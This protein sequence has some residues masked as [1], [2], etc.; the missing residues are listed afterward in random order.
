MDVRKD[1]LFELVHIFVE[2]HGGE[3]VKIRLHPDVDPEDVKKHIDRM[4]D[5]TISPYYWS[6]CGRSGVVNYFQ[7]V[8]FPSK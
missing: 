6:A 2:K 3:I 4:V 5:A 1:G 8:T 7:S